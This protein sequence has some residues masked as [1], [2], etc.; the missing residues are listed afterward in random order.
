MSQGGSRGAGGAFI[1][2]H[3]LAASLSSRQCNRCYEQWAH[4]A[5]GCSGTQLEFS[6]PL[7]DI[8]RWSKLICWT[9]LDHGPNLYWTNWAETSFKSKQRVTLQIILIFKTK[10]IPFLVLGI[11][12][13]GPLVQQG[14]VGRVPRVHHGAQLPGWELVI[15]ENQLVSKQ[16]DWARLSEWYLSCKPISHSLKTNIEIKIEQSGWNIHVLM[17][18][19][20]VL[21]RHWIVTLFCRQ[22]MNRTTIYLIFD[23]SVG[24]KVYNKLIVFIWHQMI[25]NLFVEILVA[26][27]ILKQF[28]KTI[29]FLI[30]L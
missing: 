9:K 22:M 16:I 8:K 7:K 4:L 3:I 10:K 20:I 6:M 2:T 13:Q 11:K 26:L 1:Y 19:F 5:Y 23:S 28:S 17:Y 30:S 15:S 21:G 18:C 27:R 24:R 12:E 14:L 29:D 25:I